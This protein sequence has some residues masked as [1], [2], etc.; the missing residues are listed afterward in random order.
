MK[1]V[2]IMLLFFFGLNAMSAQKVVKKSILNPN[3]VNILIDAEN[4]FKVD[5][6]T[7]ATKD[8]IVE[9]LIEGEYKNDL[10]LKIEDKE[11]STHI[12]AGFHPR[13][14]KPNDK[15]SAHKIIS[16]SLKIQIPENMKV[17]LFGTN[18]NVTTK[19]SYND[20]RIALNDGICN[21]KNVSKSAHVITQ[22]GDIY[23]ESRG[24]TIKSNTSYGRI[25]KEVIPEGNNIF[26]LSSITGNIY[27]RKTE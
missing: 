24:A 19:G 12:S 20:L 6:S 26:D 7:S 5:L 18:S 2:K 8:I 21:L 23:I 14:I 4:C 25:S 10:L 9:A 13:F 11:S 17:N 22:S 27:L 1:K 16:I 3:T 15:L